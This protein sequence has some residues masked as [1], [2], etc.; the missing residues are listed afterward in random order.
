MY[1]LQKPTVVDGRGTDGCRYIACS[2]SGSHGW[3]TAT[4]QPPGE[5]VRLQSASRGK[6]EIQST[7]PLNAYCFC[8]IEKLTNCKLSHRINWGPSAYILRKI[9]RHDSDY[10]DANTVTISLHFLLISVFCARV[11]CS[12]CRAGV[13]LSTLVSF[14]TLYL[15]SYHHVSAELRLSIYTNK[16]HTRLCIYTRAYLDFNKLQREDLFFMI[17]Y[18]ESWTNTKTIISSLFLPHPR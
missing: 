7:V 15:S 10:P 3:V 14:Y 4:A 6:S 12:G 13:E 2:S 11:S 16:A 9:Q 8:T 1:R 17:N 5:M 18:I